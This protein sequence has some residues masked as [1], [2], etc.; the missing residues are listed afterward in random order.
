MNKHSFDEQ[1]RK[2]L[3]DLEAP[4]DPTSWDLLQQKM[5]APFSE[6]EPQAVADVD[7]AVFH[8]LDRMEVPFHAADWSLFES[9]LNGKKRRRKVFWM[10]FSEAAA[11]LLLLFGFDAMSDYSNGRPI[12]RLHPEQP[13]AMAQAGVGMDANTTS[14]AAGYALATGINTSSASKGAASRLEALPSTDVNALL[15]VS[16]YLTI[17]ALNN[18]NTNGSEASP[19][20]S[21]SQKP[22]KVL[23][24]SER[25][26]P[27]RSM[28]TTIAPRKSSWYVLNYGAAEQ[29]RVRV[30]NATRTQ[31]GYGAGV[32]IGYK[33][34]K[35]GLEAGAGY[36][37]KSYEPKRE[38]EI[39]DG[40]VTSGYYGLALTGVEA[41]MLS[42]PARVTRQILSKH[43]T[44][45]SAIAG[46]TTHLV[47][48]KTYRHKRVFFPGSS[49]SAQPGSPDQQPQLKNVANGIF[50]GGSLKE[51]AYA[52]ADLG[53]RLEQQ[54]GDRFSAFIEPSYRQNIGGKGIGPQNLGISTLAIT[55][56]IITHL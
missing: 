42:I 6:E 35:W 46:V 22:Q 48:Q 36:S 49:P 7:K 15:A 12:K 27:S 19:L 30:A 24:H 26:D 9:K 1:L 47:T 40:S 29:N 56:G 43:K 10:K 3:Q 51:N 11:V 2:T 13:I 52:T 53:L 33:N 39:Y 45:V 21:L 8:S 34:K 14:S 28:V 37:F 50:E 18:L 55:A 54:I 5:D 25:I 38:I 41:E 23:L 4:Y 44:S 16:E 17:P 20:A 31:S 32:V